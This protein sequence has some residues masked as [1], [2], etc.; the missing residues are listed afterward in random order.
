MDHN[1]I[2]LFLAIID[3]I[4]ILLLLFLVLV[5]AS[6]VDKSKA[7]HEQLQGAEFGTSGDK[8]QQEKKSDDEMLAE[9]I[10]RL[11]QLLK[12]VV[13]L[14]LKHERKLSGI[15]SKGALGEQIVAEKLVDLPHDW[16]DLNVP[17]PNG[18]KAEFAL[19]TPD[20]RWIP[21]DSQWTATELLD[22]L[23]RATD[24]S[25]RNS[26]RIQVHQEV[27]KRAIAAQKYLDRGSTLGFC[28]VAVPTAVFDLC[29][30]IQA[31]LIK[32]NI[33]LISYSLLVPYILLLVDF[34]LKNSQ[35]TQVLEISH[36]LHRSAAQIELIQKYINQQ[37]VP[38][39]DIV[40]QQQTN[41]G[42]QNQG[43]Q[44]V[45][46]K[47]SQIQNEL[48]L[49]KST[50][51]PIPNADIGLI[52]KTLQRSLTQVRDGLLEGIT[53]QNGYDPDGTTK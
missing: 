50:I 2:T 35:S 52:P 16:Y 6:Y 43:L 31:G 44:Q 29:V 7:K 8:F 18:A 10:A 32:Y 38:P 1:D 4:V 17:F 14:T 24:Q 23:E 22:K 13:D 30:D 15:Q 26:L 21:I 48:N 34:Y 5:P 27:A 9:G 39:L 53:K 41:Y 12:P 49:L 33:V 28:I 36:I 37:V 47:V 40:K 42:V 19:R 25:Q 3:L 11:E 20:K 51:N 46:T 45:Y